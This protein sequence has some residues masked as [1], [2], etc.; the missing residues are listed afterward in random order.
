MTR[1]ARWLLPLLAVLVT[2]SFT[3][4]ATPVAAAPRTAAS[5]SSSVKLRSGGH[6]PALKRAPRRPG[7]IGRPAT[8]ARV[9]IG[10]TRGRPSDIRRRS[11]APLSLEER[12]AERIEEI[13]RGPL[14]SGTT[15]LYV[16]DATSGNELFSIHP[17]DPL[18][19]ASNVKLIA[20]A[21]ALEILGPDHRYLTRLVGRAPGTGG[22]IAGDVYLLGSYDPT[23]GRIDLE[24]M[25]Q[26][27]AKA[28]V[29]QIT[30]D[31]VVGGTPTRD[32]IYRSRVK[33]DVRAALPGQPP[34]VAMTPAYD[35]VT[36]D[37]KATTSKRKRGALRFHEEMITDDAG[38]TRLKVTIEGSIGK[39]KALTRWVWPRERALH[40]AHVLRAALVQ[41]GV[42]IT[43]DARIAE[44]PT[45]VASA[46]TGGWLPVELVAHHSAPLA[47]IVARVNKRSI[48]WLADRVVMTAA[49]SRF[50]E[51]PSMSRALD[52]MYEWLER[53]TGLTRKDVVIDTGSGLSYRTELSARQIVKVLR[54]AGGLGDAGGAGGDD[55]DL[56]VRR[57]AYLASLAVGGIDGTLRGR[58]LSPTLQGRLIGKTGTLRRVVALAG[59]LEPTAGRPLAFALVSNGHPPAYKA[60]VR[61]AHE[62]LIAILH[63][64]L[65]A[66]GTPP[67]AST[68]VDPPV[69]SVTAPVLPEADDG[70]EDEDDAELGL[71]PTADAPT[72]ATAR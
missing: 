5:A 54:S 35:F 70:G 47:E 55:V 69:P 11:D 44:L 48:N 26:D 15:A 36:V 62:K 66:T 61:V 28:G 2:A 49:A 57:E 68:P 67:A 21:T 52:A 37:V 10:G 22:V 40:T 53:S 17:D 38:R 29:R 4:H 46:A 50:H 45:Y 32:G 6:R 14:R 56:K 20:T 59:L 16:V 63:D 13:L 72:A 71:D 41:A 25:A 58:F 31:V 39:G 51:P 24:T 8:G 18:N 34:V 12:T 19:P 64:Y 23:L 1:A 65:A 42:T 43:G 3:T 9:S 7:R 30:G 33:V 27:L 60:R